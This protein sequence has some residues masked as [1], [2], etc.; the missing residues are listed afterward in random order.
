MLGM[1]D[2]PLQPSD[3]GDRFDSSRNES[4]CGVIEDLLPKMLDFN[5]VERGGE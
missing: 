1:S 2:E 5:A 3:T 4:D